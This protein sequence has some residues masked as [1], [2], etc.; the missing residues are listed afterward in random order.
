MIFKNLT[1]ISFCTTASKLILV[2]DPLVL[3]SIINTSLLLAGIKTVELLSIYVSR[4]IFLVMVIQSM[5]N[6]FILSCFAFVFWATANL[7]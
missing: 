5:S 6:C 4:S 3:S 1:P 7:I 2:Y